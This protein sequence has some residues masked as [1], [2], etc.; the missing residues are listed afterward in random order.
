M[1]VYLYVPI[2]LYI[3]MHFWHSRST[4]AGMCVYVPIY[5]CMCACVHAFFVCICMCV[6]VCMHACIYYPNQMESCIHENRKLLATEGRNPR[7]EISS[8][9]PRGLK[10]S[11]VLTGLGFVGLGLRLKVHA[12]HHPVMFCSSRQYI[13]E[14]HV[15]RG[16][17]VRDS[18]QGKA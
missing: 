3:C 17:D 13:P 10:K 6:Y 2:F 11:I 5:V 8:T 15:V 9:I 18:F 14:H 1:C 12:L 4:T 7:A 16:S